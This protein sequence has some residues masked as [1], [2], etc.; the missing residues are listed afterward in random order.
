MKKITRFE[1]LRTAVDRVGPVVVRFTAPWC[2]PCK[3]LAPVFNRV[4]AKIEGEIPDLE[5]VEYDFGERA[6]TGAIVKPPWSV[7][8][9]PTLL[10]FRGGKPVARIM[11]PAPDEK[12][13]R[14][15]LLFVLKRTARKPARKKAAVA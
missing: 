1:D 10:L 3:A 5:V 2:P 8:G 11:G 14:V 12:E 7:K 15:W 9:I 4:I 13:L 6:P